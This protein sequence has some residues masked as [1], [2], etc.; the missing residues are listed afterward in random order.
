MRPEFSRVAL[1]IAVALFLSACNGGSH[2]T[3]ALPQAVKTKPGG[4]GQL[5]LR[6]TLP[7]RTSSSAHRLPKYVS[8]A[9]QGAEVLV[10]ADST[11]VV[12]TFD[13]VPNSPPCTAGS[14]GASV[15]T[16]TSA[17]PGFGATTI[18]VNLYD[19]Q[20]GTG[21]SSQP[22]EPTPAPLAAALLSTGTITTTVA[23]GAANVTVP[24]V[25]SGAVAGVVAGSTGNLPTGGTAGTTTFTLEATDADAN[26]ILA[27]DG[28][29][30][31]SGSP[32]TFTLVAPASIAGI[33]IAD[34]SNGG[35]Y[36]TSLSNVKAGDIIAVASTGATPQ[37][38]GIPIEVLIGGTPA[39]IV[40]T[41]STVPAAT[42]P[43]IV[44]T[45]AGAQ[46]IAG[47]PPWDQMYGLAPGAGIAVLSDVSQGGTVT[48][49][50]SS[51]STQ[52]SCAGGGSGGVYIEHIAMGPGLQ[53]ELANVVTDQSAYDLT[54]TAVGLG[55]SAP[56]CSVNLQQVLGINAPTPWLD[57]ANDGT[58][59][60]GI[61]TGGSSV[62]LQLS[63]GPSPLGIGGGGQPGFNAHP[64][65]A[66][67][68]MWYGQYAIGFTGSNG[69][70]LV[71][72]GPQGNIA[73]FALTPA[74]VAVDYAGNAYVVDTSG[75]VYKCSLGASITCVGTSIGASTD[76][77]SVAVGADGLVYVATSAG[78]VQLNPSDFFAPPVT[79]GTTSL[80]EVQAS[81]D[82]HIYALGTDGQSI[83]IYP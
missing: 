78:L 10:T 22:S 40:T 4:K 68:G 13:L 53:L 19:Q 62:S 18:T 55:S 59:I 44:Q 73:T 25:L 17:L 75:S 1:G 47:V 5:T 46:E 54:L 24:L 41:P 11:T 63:T 37:V 42:V 31:A 38:V 26:I 64:I 43:H 28:V 81:G 27:R 14:N 77:R 30:N 29:V 20:V 71:Y 56:N 32:V 6:L 60:A 58:T 2:A 52:F 50:S 66:S 79:L 33:T 61:Y 39:G 72:A 57:A 15:C 23:E 34:L 48:G 67:I 76:H 8:A 21:S 16:L 12:S 9:T 36:A 51:G 74:S 82:G 45:A 83:Y 35:S 49:F 80:K 70:A 65:N 69:N 3:A 7:A